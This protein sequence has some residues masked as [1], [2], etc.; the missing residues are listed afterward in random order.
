MEKNKV[1]TSEAVLEAL[2][3][4]A[5]SLVGIMSPEEVVEET[6]KLPEELSAMVRA[7]LLAAIHV[8]M[9]SDARERLLKAVEK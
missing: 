3:I 9:I 4:T 6:N 5:T 7:S 8:K 1:F 2:K